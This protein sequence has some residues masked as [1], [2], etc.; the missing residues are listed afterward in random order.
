MSRGYRFQEIGVGLA[1]GRVLREKAEGHQGETHVMT[2]HDGPFFGSHDVGDAGHVPDDNIVVVDGAVLSRPLGQ[3]VVDLVA[4][5]VHTGRV[6]LV[7]R[8]LRHP[9]LMVEEA[10]FFANDGTRRHEGCGLRAG[11]QHIA[12][13]LSQAIVL[14]GVHD[15]PA[16]GAFVVDVALCL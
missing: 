12:G 13:M 5:G 8:V 1:H 10:G 7:F 2:R 6:F 3:A 9:E 16:A 11:H 4:G 14:I 15:V